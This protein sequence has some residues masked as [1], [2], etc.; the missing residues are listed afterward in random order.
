M[1]SFLPWGPALFIKQPIASR[2]G[3]NL[4]KI[5]LQQAHTWMLKAFKAMVVQASHIG[6][7]KTT[8]A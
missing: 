3:Y 4:L 5:C 8:W 7:R 2:S 1:M 6:P